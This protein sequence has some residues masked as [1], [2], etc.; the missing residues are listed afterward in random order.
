MGTAFLYGNGSETE[1]AVK[2]VGGTQKPSNAKQG[3][4]WVNTDQKITVWTIQV[5]EPAEPIEGMVWIYN[6]TSTRF[7]ALKKNGI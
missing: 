2:V 6:L 1:L 7:N 4:I 3:T 5:E